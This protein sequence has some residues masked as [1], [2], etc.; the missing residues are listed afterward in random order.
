VAPPNSPVSVLKGVGSEPG[1]Q[2]D[3]G[4][5]KQIKSEI[6]LK[7]KELQT[8]E[9]EEWRREACQKEEQRLQVIAE[10]VL[11]EMRE[12]PDREKAEIIG[13]NAQV[14]K[15]KMHSQVLV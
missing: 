7:V 2:F 6:T 5:I 8:L 3:E 11:T 13:E 9:T 14:R 15:G 4:E 1:K 12:S 10:K